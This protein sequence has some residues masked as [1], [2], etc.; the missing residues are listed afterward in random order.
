MRQKTRKEE[1][2]KRG[3]REEMMLTRETEERD[4][5]WGVRKEGREGGSK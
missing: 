5:G 4:Q 3:E 1:G 2:Y